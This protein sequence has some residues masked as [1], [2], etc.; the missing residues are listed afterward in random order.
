MPRPPDDND[1]PRP[2]FKPKRER[3]TRT[4]RR[5]NSA[6]TYIGTTPVPP[7]LQQTAEVLFSLTP[8]Q[9]LAVMIKAV[10]E[11]RMTDEEIALICNTY[12]D[13]VMNWG[14]WKD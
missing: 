13:A 14:I 6:T 4:P 12:Y 2:A 10:A 1:L 8:I 9:F 7:E 5:I 3:C 11:D